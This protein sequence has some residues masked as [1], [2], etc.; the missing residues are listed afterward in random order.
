MNEGQ[1][2]NHNV[3]EGIS[4]LSEIFRISPKMNKAFINFCAFLEFAIVNVSLEC[5]KEIIVFMKKKIIK[6]VP[7]R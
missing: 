6:K 5:N 2:L 3:E 1:C 7:I 4:F